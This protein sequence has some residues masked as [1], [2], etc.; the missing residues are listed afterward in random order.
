MDYVPPHLRASRKELKSPTDSCKE[1]IDNIKIIT[2]SPYGRLD[3]LEGLRASKN[4]PYKEP[5]FIQRYAIPVLLNSHPLLCRAP[6]GMG[7]T[8]CFLLPLIENMKYAQGTRVCIISPTRELCEQIK[9]EAVRITKSL[10]VESVYGGTSA[11]PTYKNVNILVATPGRLLDLLKSKRVVFS[12]VDSLVLDEADKLLDMGFEKDI[13]SIKE[14]VPSSANVYLFSAT[15]HKNLS[16]IID[17]FLPSSKCVIEVENETAENIKQSVIRV[18]NKD[19]S[20]R[21][22]LSKLDVHAS[23]KS[24]KIADRCLIFVEKKITA[25]E[26]G[27]KVKSWG[28]LA[29]ALH[30]DKEQS[31]R[32]S[33]LNKFKKGTLPILVATSVAAR[34]IDVKDIKLVVNYDFPRDIK[35]YIH[36]IGRTGR[37]GKEGTSISFVGNDLSPEMRL[38]VVQVLKESKND[39]PDFLLGDSPLSRDK[40]LYRSYRSD[41]GKVKDGSRDARELKAFKNLTV[42]KPDLKLNGEKEDSDDEVPGVW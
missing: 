10:R 30:G 34:G 20:L 33:I 15:F 42:S 32:L 41:N 14:F 28:Y 1:T 22:I 38:E 37:Q 40:K 21:E 26:L 18:K 3:S 17:D 5:T 9:E 19:S 24:D 4:L 12:Y 23:W 36:R 8:I 25:D 35:E 29:A 27:E 2:N 6:T 39:V 31:D 13:R 16:G 7:K 11:L